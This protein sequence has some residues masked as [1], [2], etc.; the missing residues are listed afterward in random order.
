ML[1]MEEYHIKITDKKDIF[2]NVLLKKRVKLMI[3][4]NEN[5]RPL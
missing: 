5:E 1:V 3:L 2:G 4:T